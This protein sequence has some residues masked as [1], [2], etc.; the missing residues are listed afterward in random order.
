MQ[1]ETVNMRLK[2][3]RSIYR[4]LKHIAVDKGVPVS[5][6][7]LAAAEELIR[8]AALPYSAKSGKR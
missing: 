8:A 4:Q 5:D 1:P 3:P 7:L 6:L 2:M